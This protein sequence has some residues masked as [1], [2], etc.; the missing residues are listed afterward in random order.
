[1]GGRSILEVFEGKKALEEV[2]EDVP[3]IYDLGLFG[4][5]QHVYIARLS[6]YRYL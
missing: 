1:M 4:R 5:S 3:F 2:A 6:C